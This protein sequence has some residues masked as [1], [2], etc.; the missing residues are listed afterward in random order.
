MI[1][2]TGSA[3]RFDIYEP[4]KEFGSVIWRRLCVME[5]ILY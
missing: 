4:A 3:G 5:M 2:G 1:R